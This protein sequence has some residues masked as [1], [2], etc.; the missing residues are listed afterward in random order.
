MGLNTGCWKTGRTYTMTP[1]AGLVISIFL[2]PG[3]NAAL[4]YT[5]YWAAENALNV[6]VS[7]VVTFLLPKS[8][9]TTVIMNVLPGSI[10]LTNTWIFP[11]GAT[12]VQ[13]AAISQSQ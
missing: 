8:G 11:E 5:V 4:G 9:Q 2:Q 6:A 1:I 3:G 13:L 7:V 12:N 10:S